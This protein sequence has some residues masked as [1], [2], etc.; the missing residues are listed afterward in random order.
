MLVR[1]AQTEEQWRAMLGRHV[2]ALQQMLN[3]EGY[4]LLDAYMALIEADV[5]NKL[6]NVTSGDIAMKLAGELRVIE[7][8]RKFAPRT[9]DAYMKELHQDRR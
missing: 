2:E 7:E 5:R 9:R 8:V 3:G 4:A 6:A 1:G